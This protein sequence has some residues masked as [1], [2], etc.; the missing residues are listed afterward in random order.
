MKYL[1]NYYYMPGPEIFLLSKKVIKH[2][3]TEEGANM[4][5]MGRGGE[6]RI[7]QSD[8]FSYALTGNVKN[9]YKPGLQG[10]LC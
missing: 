1:L 8:I 2:P 4:T 3:G 7:F 5:F 9:T 6:G 10:I